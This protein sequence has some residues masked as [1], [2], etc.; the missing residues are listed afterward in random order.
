MELLVLIIKQS[1]FLDDIL[2]GFLDIGINGATVVDC[3]GMGQILAAEV[4]IFAGLKDLMPGGNIGNHMILSM[5]EKNKIDK[6][7][8]LIEEICGD[9]R[10]NELGVLF[11]MPI[12]R[13]ICPNITND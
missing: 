6:A 10:K 7:I 13:F 4:P 11:T 5:A 2:M 8:S 9:F 3:R 1:R 12:S